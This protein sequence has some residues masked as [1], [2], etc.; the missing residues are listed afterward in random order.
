VFQGAASVFDFRI[1]CIPLHHA[2]HWVLGVVNIQLKAIAIFDSNNS[3]PEDFV[4]KFHCDIKSW[5]KL[6]ADADGRQEAVGDI[7]SWHWSG[8]LG[9]MMQDVNNCGVNTV[10]NMYCVSNG[11]MIPGPTRK[12]DGDKLRMRCLAYALKLNVSMLPEGEV[13]P[14]MG[15]Q[16]EMMA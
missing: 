9:S 16:L 3:M 4:K 10:L 12:W 2:L 14:E 15:V 11:M 13:L 8:R 6:R 5:L 7:A 1:I